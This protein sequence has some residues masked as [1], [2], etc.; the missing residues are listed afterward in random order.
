MRCVGCSCDERQLGYQDGQLG[1]HGAATGG[2]SSMEEVVGFQAF[3]LYGRNW[4]GHSLEKRARPVS[5]RPKKGK[6]NEKIDSYPHFCCLGNRCDASAWRHRSDTKKRGERIKRD[7]KGP[8]GE[9]ALLRSQLVGK[10]KRAK[11]Q[12]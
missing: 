7:R 12:A 8:P 11:L 6:L 9:K 1:Y 4:H 10:L 5:A 2:M 3:T